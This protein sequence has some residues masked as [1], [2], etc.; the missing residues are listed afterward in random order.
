MNESTYNTWFAF[1]L[2]NGHGAN[3]GKWA[4]GFQEKPGSEIRIAKWPSGGK[5]VFEKRDGACTHAEQ[6]NSTGARP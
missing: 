2:C 4:V 5:A 3:A 6:L 1:R